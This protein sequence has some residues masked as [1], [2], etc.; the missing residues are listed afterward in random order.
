[1][2]KNKVSCLVTGLFMTDHLGEFMIL[3]VQ[4]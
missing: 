3:I 4:D 1:M 2:Y